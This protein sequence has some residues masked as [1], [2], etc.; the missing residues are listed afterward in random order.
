MK[1]NDDSIYS[2]P[3]LIALLK[4]MQNVNSVTS[5]PYEIKKDGSHVVVSRRKP[6][7]SRMT[8]SIKATS[9]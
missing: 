6:D 8:R 4:K 1:T 3:R 9:K 5:Q 2:D 7:Q